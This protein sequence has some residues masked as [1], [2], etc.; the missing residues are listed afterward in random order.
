LPTTCSNSPR[1]QLVLGRDTD[2][3]LVKLA[4]KGQNVL[5]AGDPASGKSWVTGLLC[6]QLIAQQYSVCLLDPEG[7]YAELETLSGVQLLGGDEP[8]PSLEHLA[9]ALRHPDVSVV[10]DLT[11]LDLQAK[12][13]YV[14]A[15]LRMLRDL[16]RDTGLPH[17]IVVDEAHY[18]LHDPAE[19]AVLDLAAGGH[20]LVTWRITGL[21]AAIL[22]TMECVIVT[23]ESDAAEACLLRE[24]FQGDGD[25][26]HWQRQLGTLEL[27]EAALL[28]TGAEERGTLRRFR[29][30]PRLTRHVR[31]RQKYLDVPVEPARAFRV[32]FDDGEAGP[33][34]CTLQQLVD[35]ATSTPGMRIAAHVRRG[36]FSRWIDDVCHDHALAATIRELEGRSRAGSLPDFNCALVQAIKGRY[37]V[38]DD[39]AW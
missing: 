8:P 17:R 39:L 16:R 35:L 9:R 3:A 1:R 26:E 33:Q 21:D 23:Q 2:C 6:E 38:V 14:L 27:D 15:A 19:T 11:R 12:H 25:P 24:I 30:A 32:E 37:G 28:A 34:V 18:F 29:L 36:D 7:D 20:M 31:H 10:V 5:I 4:I 13:D 22:A